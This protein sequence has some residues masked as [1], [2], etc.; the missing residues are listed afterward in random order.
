MAFLA[1][2][3][4][5]EVRR[6]VAVRLKMGAQ[7]E[8]S[9]LLRDTID[10]YIRRAARELLLEAHWVELRNIYKLPL[11]NGNAWYDWPDNM[12]PG[13]LERIMVV[14]VNGGEY[15][16]QSGIH[17]EE[18]AAAGPSDGNWQAG[19]FPDAEGVFTASGIAAADL[20]LAMPLRYEIVNQQLCVLP[21]PDSARYP[22][23]LIEG[24][25]RP[26]APEHNDDPIPLDREAIIQKATVIGKFDFNK[27]DAA[28]AKVLF[29]EYIRRLRPTQ[30][31]GESI[32][33]GGPF[34]R[35]FPY[36]RPRNAGVDPN[37]NYWLLP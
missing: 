2:P 30:S 27:P 25:M 13:R 7:A 20:P 36:A 24:F 31:E 17:P 33:I 12:D 29:D 15:R 5:A 16:L 14:A 4:L 35:K 26:V 22:H 9:P 8:Q 1:P 6:S 3:T 18:R 11:I 34:S 19:E 32:R 37:S 21:L 28:A 10:E 23:L